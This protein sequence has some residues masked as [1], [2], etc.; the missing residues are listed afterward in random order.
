MLIFPRLCLHFSSGASSLVSSALFAVHPVHTEAVS[1]VVGRAELLSAVAF[2][3][4]LLYY[5]H[6]RYQHKTSA[7]QECGV[8][9]VVAILGLLCKE[10]ALTV[11][12]VCCIYEIISPKEIII[13]NNLLVLCIDCDMLRRAWMSQSVAHSILRAN[14]FFSKEHAS[15]QLEP[16]HSSNYHVSR[17]SRTA[18]FSA[19]C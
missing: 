14:T 2:L 4:A 16:F 6:T 15:Q 9:S 7:W 1:G 17:K 8:T 18:L 10:Q 3:C 5:I 19:K 12:A 13:N 11:L